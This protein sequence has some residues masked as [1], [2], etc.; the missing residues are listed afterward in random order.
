VS[1][2]SK[3]TQTL[4]K[5]LHALSSRTATYQKEVQDLGMCFVAPAQ[6][7]NYFCERVS[8]STIP[9]L[10]SS[11]IPDIPQVR[12][13]LHMCVLRPKRPTKGQCRK[14]RLKTLHNQRTTLSNAPSIIPKSSV[15][16]TCSIS[17]YDQKSICSNA[18]YQ[19][20]SAI[21]PCLLRCQKPRTSHPWT[22]SALLYNRNT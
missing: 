3:S 22:L 10:R 2:P 12:Y 15:L 6:S 11:D 1:V 4:R 5:Q 19:K 7:I 20:P 13:T 8:T 18:R 21:L 14:S 17:P 9:P 16:Q